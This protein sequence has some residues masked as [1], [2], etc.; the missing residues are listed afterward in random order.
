MKLVF[1]L[2]QWPVFLVCLF[3]SSCLK[4][5]DETARGPKSEIAARNFV[6][7]GN[8]L[9]VWWDN[10]KIN[11]TPLEFGSATGAAG[12][13]YTTVGGGLHAIR[14][15]ANNIPVYNKIFSFETG[16]R[17]SVFAYDS[18]KN[19]AVK[20]LILKDD[21]AVVDTVARL[22]FLQFIPG[23]DTLTAV[24]VNNNLG[25]N[26]SR[27]YLGNNISGSEN[28]FALVLPPA[29]YSIL[30]RRKNTTI[31]QLP[32]FNATAGKNYS[33]ISKGIVNG[34]GPYQQTIQVVAHN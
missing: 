5:S 14:I 25:Y 27:S 7:T 18:L 20:V 22:R 28:E 12:R 15:T 13:L 9:D 8:T 23:P 2:Q 33:L 24:L 16:A 4:N 19:E 29:T 26:I 31:A 6:V 1:R 10:D 17:Y 3:A 32:S 11:D 21:T 34:T 30:L